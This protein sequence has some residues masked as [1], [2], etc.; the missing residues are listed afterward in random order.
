MNVSRRVFMLAA[1][2]SLTLAPAASAQSGR[3]RGRGN[4]DPATEMTLSGQVTKAENV[5]PTG[6]SGR[7]GMGGLHLELKSGGETVV[8]HL[9][10]AAFVKEKGFTV[11]VGDRLDITGSRVTLDGNVVVL[12]RQIKKDD[13]T[14]TLRDASGRPLWSG[15][16]RRR[17]S[18]QKEASLD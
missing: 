6:R 13:R 1:L 3:G 18:S 15:G 16:G 4:Y 17:G 9:G 14:L 7:R 11:A 10:P 5:L 12:A 2:V 8:V